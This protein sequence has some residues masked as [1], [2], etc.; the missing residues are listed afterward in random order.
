M[1]TLFEPTSTTLLIDSFIAVSKFATQNIYVTRPDAHRI[2]VLNI[3]ARM[4][5]AFLGGTTFGFVNG[6]WLDARFNIPQFM[7]ASANGRLLYVMDFGNRAIRSVELDHIDTMV[8]T[9]VGGGS[10]VAA[11][12]QESGWNIPGLFEIPT[13]MCLSPNQL[14]MYI[15]D[16]RT[17]R[18]LQF[19]I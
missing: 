18:R 7:I 3:N 9:V 4:R 1:V 16:H 11:K 19:S 2:S 13:V 14:F 12:Q 5:T 17:M 6:R 10:T 8:G 15:G